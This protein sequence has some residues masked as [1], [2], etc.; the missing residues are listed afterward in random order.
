M[1]KNDLEHLRGLIENLMNFSA[2]HSNTLNK[3]SAPLWSYAKEK[4]NIT[5]D[6]MVLNDLF[7]YLN[8][9]GLSNND[10]SDEELSFINHIFGM[11]FTKGDLIEYLNLE[12]LI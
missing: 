3:D 5:L 10:I 12:I 11:N 1:N 7:I 9:L 6:A 8:F 4:Y 2:K